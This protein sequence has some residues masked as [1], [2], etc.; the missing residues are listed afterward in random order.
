MT[1][2]NETI[3]AARIR[4]AEKARLEGV[5]ILRD[6]RDNRHYAT[7]TSQPGVLYF[8][9]LMS[10]TCKGFMTHQ[11]CRHHSALLLAYGQIGPEP[12]APTC[13]NCGDTNV[14][15]PDTRSRWVGGSRDGYADAAT[16]HRCDACHRREGREVDR[17]AA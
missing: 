11:R 17:I 14:V 16:L 4:L 2:I 15:H 3:D 12:T 9:T 8:V 6:N 5:R 1:A 13:A 7:S 10:C